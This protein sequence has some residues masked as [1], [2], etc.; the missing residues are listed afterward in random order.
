MICIAPN[1]SGCSSVPPTL[2]VA[3]T[4]PEEI[5]SLAYSSSTARSTEPVTTSPSCPSA[6]PQSP[7]SPSIF[8]RLS[9]AVT[10]STGV[11]RIS[12]PPG[13]R[14]IRAGRASWASIV[15]AASDSPVS[16]RRPCQVG[17]SRSTPAAW[18]VP[19]PSAWTAQ[20]A[21]ASPAARSCTGT[22]SEWVVSS[23]EGL[24]IGPE[25]ASRCCSLPAVEFS[26][27]PSSSAVTAATPAGMRS[28]ETASSLQDSVPSSGSGRSKLSKVPARSP[29]TIPDA[30]PSSS[31]PKNG[32][33]SARTR[34][35]SRAC[36]GRGPSGSATSPEKAASSPGRRRVPSSIRTASFVRVPRAAAVTGVA[37]PSVSWV[38]AS[39]S[40]RAAAA[41][42]SPAIV[43]LTS[44]R[45]SGS[46]SSIPSARTIS[47]TAS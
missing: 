8:I 33:S 36:S 39:N 3:L 38:A 32:A 5:T 17:R 35:R 42:H 41:D 30:S 47:D 11:T 20:P 44:P 9:R 34:E 29:S 28:P 6:R 21:Y 24:P 10:S 22:P 13:S 15:A 14:S 40:S 12:R 7:Y 46:S 1:S 43:P 37:S 18:S 27:N 2:S 45:P 23:N 25:I 26:W 4:V 19:R 31:Q 16:S